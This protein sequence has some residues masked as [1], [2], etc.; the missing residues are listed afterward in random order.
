MPREYLAQSPCRSERRGRGNNGLKEDI[1]EDVYECRRLGQIKIKPI[2][3]SYDV[4]S[5]TCLH[6]LQECRLYT[7]DE[8]GSVCTNKAGEAALSNKVTVWEPSLPILVVENVKEGEQKGLP[9]QEDDGCELFH[10]VCEITCGVITER[11]WKEAVKDDVGLREREMCT[12]LSYL[13]V[14]G[15]HGDA[16]RIPHA[17]SMEKRM[18]RTGKQRFERGRRGGRLRVS[19]AG[20]N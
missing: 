4:F 17:V 18:S 16:E 7:G 10:D 15:L 3:K 20:A 19:M 13:R 5:F 11:E 1:K 14:S 6:C 12:V 8:V 2:F 9:G